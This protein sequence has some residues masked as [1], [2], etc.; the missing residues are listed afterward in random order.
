MSHRIVKD[1][2]CQDCVFVFSIHTHLFRRTSPYCPKCAD[3]VSVVPYEKKI[4]NEK[5]FWTEEEMEYIDRI[6]GG[7]LLVYQVAAKL[8]RTSKSIQRRL[9]RRRREKQL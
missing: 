9:D 7:E 5:K 3:H 6:L 8:G 4:I 2:I 1:F